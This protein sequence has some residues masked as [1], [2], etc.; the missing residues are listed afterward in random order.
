M[1]FIIVIVLLFLL[2]QYWKKHQEAPKVKKSKGDVI[3][4]EVVR[5]EDIERGP[6]PYKKRPYLQDRSERLLFEG[7][8]EHLR[9]Y[10]VEIYP[11]VDMLKL[12]YVPPASKNY[13]AYINRLS[14][15]SADLVLC[16]AQT[17]KPLVAICLDK[18]N[19]EM[20]QRRESDLFIDRAFE[21]AGFPLVRFMASEDGYNWEEVM[22]TLRGYLVE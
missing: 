22:Q 5:H 13:M 19:V 14:G 10:A 9:A 4:I 11:Q 21:T 20:S 15:K 3:D 8:K 7:L 6:L 17:L 12:L 16:D 1:Q 18:M 2:Y